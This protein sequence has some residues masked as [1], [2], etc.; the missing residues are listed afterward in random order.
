MTL[1]KFRKF[2]PVIVCTS[3]LFLVSG[4][5]F[6][7]TIAYTFDETCHGTMVSSG[8]S[9]PMTCQMWMDP[10]SGMTTVRY[11]LLSLGVVTGDLLVRDPDG[12][13]SDI[14]RFNDDMR[15]VFVFSSD[16]D[17]RTDPA[18]IGIPFPDITS[19]ISVADEVDLGGGRFGVT[20]TPQRAASPGFVALDAGTV[21]YTFSDVGAAASAPEPGTYLLIG[22]PLVWLSLR[23]RK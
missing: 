18:D 14:L 23:R 12:R 2:V 9:T 16:R 22:V 15:S 10:V 6:G 1:L 11:N 20:N 19:P 4:A 5:A 8:G 21:T 13:I 3:A 17:G 7:A